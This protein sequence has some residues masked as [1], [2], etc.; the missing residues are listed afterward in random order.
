MVQH[1]SNANI[2]ACGLVLNYMIGTSKRA[3]FSKQ[4]R[5]PTLKL[6]KILHKWKTSIWCR[7]LNLNNPLND[8]P[9]NSLTD[10]NASL[11]C[12]QRKNKESGHTPWLTTHLWGVLELRDG[13]RKNE[14]RLIT[15]IDLHK[16]N[17][18]LINT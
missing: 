7:Y 15:R 16:P 5:W 1:H 14:R 17:K 3:K 8:V 12:E 9:L 13:T 18:E 6:L 4:S 11:K 2:N 10:S